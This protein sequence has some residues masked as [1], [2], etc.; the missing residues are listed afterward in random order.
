MTRSNKTQLPKNILVVYALD[1]HNER[2]IGT[3]SHLHALEYSSIPHQITYYNAYG[4]KPGWSLLEDISGSVP[5]ELEQKKFDILILHNTFLCYRWTYAYFYKWKY[6]FR[7][8]AEIAPLKLAIP[9]DEFDHHSLLDEWLYEWNVDAIIDVHYHTAG[10]GIF[11]P[12]MHDKV[13]IYACLPGYI[14]DQLA[15]KYAPQLLPSSQRRLD[16]VYRANHLPYR[17]GS[18]GQ[19]KYYIGEV[20]AARAQELGYR[21]N[22]STCPQDAIIGEH[23]LDF[24][25]SSKSVIGVEGGATAMDWHGEVRAKEETLRK[26]MPNLTFEQFKATMPSDWDSQHFLTITPRHFEAIITKTCQI[27]VEG[28]YRG[29]L[30]PDVHYIPLKKDFSNLDEALDKLRD[31][32][33]V[34]T[35]VERAYEDIY[36][37]GRYSYRTFAELIERAI[38]DAEQLQKNKQEGKITL[39]TTDEQP[40]QALERSLIAER[41]SKALLEAK[42]IEMGAELKAQQAAQ[43]VVEQVAQQVAQQASLISGLK[44]Y[45]AKWNERLALLVLG[46][47]TVSVIV[48]LVIALWLR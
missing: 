1:D 21:C 38:S 46:S 45:Q 28:E 11:Y 10:K 31:V 47:M 9:Q 18:A 42:L 48:S 15:Q 43:Q 32:R 34:E 20:V 29:I 17:F 23:W 12:L 40:T 30:K 33:Y 8:I 39:M 13:P 7:W 25:S 26:L 14:D 2:R 19:M 41:H 27:L 22:I 3:I 6:F 5:A 35:M 44:T 24:L 16:I 37:S 4:V 36:L